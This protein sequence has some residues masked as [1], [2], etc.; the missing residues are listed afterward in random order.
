MT[1]WQLVGCVGGIAAM[2]FATAVGVGAKK[3]EKNDR[4][5]RASVSRALVIWRRLRCRGSVRFG[6]GCGGAKRSQ[7]HTQFYK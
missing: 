7:F 4:A 5:V 1:L 6:R 3:D 2:R